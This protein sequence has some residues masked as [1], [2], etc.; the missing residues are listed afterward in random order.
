MRRWLH[1]LLLVAIVFAPTVARAQSAPQMTAQ[2]DVDTVGV[3]DVVHLELTA[4]SSDGMPT[5]PQPGATPGFSVRGQSAS[6]SQTH[7]SINGNRMDR[8]GLTVDWAL[9][10]QRVGT[11]SIGPPT[12]AVGS[13]RFAARP[14]TIHVVPAGQ[15]PQRQQ[16]QQQQQ[17]TI[18]F[19]QGPGFT[20]FDPWRGLFPGLDPGTQPSVTTD[21]KLALDAPAGSYYFLHA[22]VDTAS[23]VVGQQVTFSVYEY[24]D[25]STGASIE[26]DPAD[27]HDPGAAEFVKHPLLRD[28]QEAILVG[29]AQVGNRI[30][31][32]D[33]VRRWALFPLHAGDL[34][35]GPMSVTLVRPR[36]ASGTKR[37]TDALH[38]RVTDPPAAGRPPGYALG[39]VG[40][41]SL[42]AQV[43]PRG[44]EQNGAIGVHVELSGTGNVPA[45]LAPPARTGVE[46]LAP[47]VHEQLG[48]VGRDAT[49]FGGK[50]SFDYVVRV[51][52][53]GDVELGEMSLPFWDPEQKRYSVARA[54][55]G[56]VH[57]KPGTAAPAASGEPAEQEVLSGLPGPRDALEGTAPSHA[58]LD[59]SRLFW[60]L[61]VGAWPAAFGIAVAGTSAGRRLARVWR[62]RKASPA[63]DLKD[64]VSAANAACHGKDARAVDAAI[65]HALEAAAIAHAGVN[66][67][68]AVGDEVVHRLEGAGIARDAASRVAELLR[69]CEA[70]RFAPDAADVLSARDR[71]LRAQGAI[72]QLEK[73]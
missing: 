70:A 15:G 50:R 21:P 29:Y 55:L 68:G 20:P 6:P 1:L 4:Q 40:H 65:A 44:L 67:R 63:S 24:L 62:T 8:F 36:S 34:V 32:V 71:W 58:H 14:V 22:A 60:L 51:H 30:W 43:T 53:A 42:S 18:P 46:W 37:T 27:V 11:F 28:D 10:A 73:R 19:P 39:D 52:R 41:F 23:A 69:E 17:G 49:T 54:A 31:K 48:S 26:V 3:G 13:S 38:I 9:Q 7:I 57:V 64:R 61:G 2:A 16:Q 35:I 33:L 59:D 25:E 5:D 45:A 56:T 12:V 72:R 47:E 66:V